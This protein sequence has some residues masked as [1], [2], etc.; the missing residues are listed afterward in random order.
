[1]GETPPELGSAAAR[2]ADSVGVAWYSCTITFGMNARRVTAD[3][4][5]RTLPLGGRNP[6]PIGIAYRLL[7]VLRVEE[8]DGHVA[9]RPVRPRGEPIEEPDARALVVGGAPDDRPPAGAP[10]M[11]DFD[12][13]ARRG[14]DP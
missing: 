6:P 9:A 8:H 1:M 7:T 13:A 3:S 10:V 11:G 12:V 4:S 2:N 14:G 5:V